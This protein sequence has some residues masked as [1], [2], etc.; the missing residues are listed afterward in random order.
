MCPLAAFLLL[1][2][3]YLKELCHGDFHG[4]G[5]MVILLVMV[6]WCFFFCQNCLKFELST[7]VVHK[8][9]IEH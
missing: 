5:V 6:S 3:E 2:T 9:V 1:T 4:H 8:V 7:F